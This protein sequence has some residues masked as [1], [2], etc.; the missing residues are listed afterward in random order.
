MPSQAVEPV[1][2]ATMLF[3]W[4]SPQHLYPTVTVPEKELSCSKSLPRMTE[5]AWDTSL[6]DIVI[7]R[8]NSDQCHSLCGNQTS[9][10]WSKQQKGGRQVGRIAMRCWR[11]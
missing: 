7:K 9:H 10:V 2:K 4:P 11:T 1:N 3:C 6:G 8:S 5:D